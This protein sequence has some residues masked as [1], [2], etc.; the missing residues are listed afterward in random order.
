MTEQPLNAKLD[1]F[2]LIQSWL[3]PCN[4]LCR[5]QAAINNS[6]SAASTAHRQAWTHIYWNL[7]ERHQPARRHKVTDRQ[8]DRQGVSDICLWCQPL[9]RCLLDVFLFSPLQNLLNDVVN[10]LLFVCEAR[11]RLTLQLSKS[12]F[13]REVFFHS[14]E[15][16]WQRLQI[17][18]WF[19]P[20]VIRRCQ[21]HL[22]VDVGKGAM[23]LLTTKIG[24]HYSPLQPRGALFHSL[25]ETQGIMGKMKGRWQ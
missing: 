15:E 23:S 1:K 13:S 21:L 16:D 7:Q 9:C 25:E 18:V 4:C 5:P 19:L 8:T 10:F 11:M 6:K 22:S 3:C 12:F 24:S 20:L 17:I 2:Q 14:L